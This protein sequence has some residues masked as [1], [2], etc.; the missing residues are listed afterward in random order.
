MSNHNYSDFTCRCGAQII[1]PTRL[2]IWRAGA[3]R[4]CSKAC[5][6]VALR[7]L[8]DAAHMPEVTGEPICEIMAKQAEILQRQSEVTR[9]AMTEKY[10]KVKTKESQSA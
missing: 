1:A 9:A 2:E 6:Q 10:A 4:C 3:E 5:Q 7:E 8:A